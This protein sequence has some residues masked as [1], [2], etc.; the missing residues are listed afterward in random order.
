[1]IAGRNH[2]LTPQQIILLEAAMKQV[3]WGLM[4]FS[5]GDDPL[6]QVAD[7]P[8]VPMTRREMDVIGLLAQGMTSPEIG[9][10]LTISNH[11]VDW[12]INGIQRKFKAKN[13][14]H[15]IAMA[16]RFGLIS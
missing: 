2:E 12:Y 16:F 8:D 10:E 1:M 15:V 9:K 14:Q 6:L 4:A 11:T 5:C 13:R 3:F 7:V